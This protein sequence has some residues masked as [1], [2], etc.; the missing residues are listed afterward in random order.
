MSEF[1]IEDTKRIAK[2]MGE[3]QMKVFLSEANGKLLSQETDKRMEKLE[4]LEKR[5]KELFAEE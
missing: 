3:E 4:R 2:G 1:D 5:G